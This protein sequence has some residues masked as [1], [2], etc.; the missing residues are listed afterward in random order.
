MERLQNLGLVGK[1]RRGSSGISWAVA[2]AH[3]ALLPRPWVYAWGW[4]PEGLICCCR[5]SYS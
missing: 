1:L 2:R 5:M 4:V 3:L